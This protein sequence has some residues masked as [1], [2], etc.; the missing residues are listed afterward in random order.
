MKSALLILLILV[1]LAHGSAHADQK[2][3]QDE[4]P[5]IYIMPWEG[6]LGIM[7]EA[8]K[9]RYLKNVAKH[10][11]DLPVNVKSLQ[12]LQ[13]MA[14]DRVAWNKLREDVL[15]ACDEPSAKKA[16][17]KM[18]EDYNRSEL[19]NSSDRNPHRGE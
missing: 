19:E 17:K 4:E 15:N 10:I 8:P 1:P 5:P 9:N 16:C 6:D 3:S 18:L 11:K 14:K 7:E 13:A 2:F 12:Q